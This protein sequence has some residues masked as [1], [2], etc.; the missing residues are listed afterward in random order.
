M[1]K[2]SVGFGKVVA[3]KNALAHMVENANQREE[4]HARE[5]GGRMVGGSGGG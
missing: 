2:L 5:N 4:D 3:V 1:W